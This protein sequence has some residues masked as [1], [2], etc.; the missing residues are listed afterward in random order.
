M[1]SVLNSVK[2]GGVEIDF[3]EVKNNSDQT[4]GYKIKGLSVVK[5]VPSVYEVEMEENSTSALQIIE[6]I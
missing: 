1:S 4:I 5:G 3:N 6:V 2:S